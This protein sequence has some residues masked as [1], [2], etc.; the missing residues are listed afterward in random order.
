MGP[1][2][3]FNRWGF[4]EQI[5]IDLDL[6]PYCRSPNGPFYIYSTIHCPAIALSL[7]RIE[8]PG[9]PVNS[10]RIVSSNTG[11]RDGL[12]ADDPGLRTTNPAEDM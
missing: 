7:I 8:Y 9:C 3:F 10:G 6:G 12:Y 2:R 11:Q 4:M 5:I 1:G